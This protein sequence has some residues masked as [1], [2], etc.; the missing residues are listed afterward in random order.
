MIKFREGL[1]PPVPLDE[2]ED[3]YWD[4]RPDDADTWVPYAQLDEAV[5]LARRTGKLASALPSVVEPGQDC[6]ETLLSGRPLLPWQLSAERARTDE[7][8]VQ[9]SMIVVARMLW[10]RIGGFDQQFVGW[11]GED[12][13]FWQA[14][15]H[16]TCGTRALMW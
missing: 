10:Q 11:G 5:R 9:S 6:T 16:S 14:A 7:I 3:M 4:A 15:R 1:R 13:A 2:V 8:T 12:N